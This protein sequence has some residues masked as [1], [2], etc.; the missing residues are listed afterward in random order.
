VIL[1]SY[2]DT[3]KLGSFVDPVN[4]EAQAFRIVAALWHQSDSP[5]K[6]SAIATQWQVFTSSLVLFTL[7]LPTTYISF[8]IIYCNILVL[9]PIPILLY[10]K[11]KK[12]EG[13]F[14][15]MCK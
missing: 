12:V 7:N 3:G 9:T 13:K 10:T 1:V 5:L 4:M 6:S 14:S 11:R 2:L 8:Q 15:Q